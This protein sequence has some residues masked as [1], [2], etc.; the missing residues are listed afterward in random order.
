MRVALIHPSIPSKY[1]KHNFFIENLKLMPLGLLYL[2]AAL[3]QAGFETVLF[4]EMYYGGNAEG[5]AAEIARHQ[6]D[7]IGISNNTLTYENSKKLAGRLKG[8][9]G[10]EPL[11]VFGGHHTNYL[12]EDVLKDGICDCVI[13]GEAEHV[14]TEVVKAFQSEKKSKAFFSKLGDL[15]GV[16]VWDS[17]RQAV[18]GNYHFNLIENLDELP[19][20]DRRQIDTSFYNYHSVIFSRGCNGRCIFCSCSTDYRR[21]SIENILDELNELK[22]NR[23]VSGALSDDVYFLDN[24]FLADPVFTDKLLGRF[25][26]EGLRLEWGCEC[27]VDQIDPVLAKRMAGSGCKK[28]LFGIESIH[29]P[30]QR[31]IRKRLPQRDQIIDISKTCI[32]CGIEVHTS[33][34]IGLPGESRESLIEAFEFMKELRDIGAKPKARFLIPYPGTPVYRDPE[35]YNIKI[36]T[37]LW[38]NYGSYDCIVETEHLSKGEIEALYFEYCLELMEVI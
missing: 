30:I 2:S 28:V 18:G 22:S 33:F 35:K 37:R 12:Y 3:E 5:F 10:E 21:R 25:D 38:D 14:F 7:V 20:P 23:L 36:L 29:Q 4:D 8:I 24:N 32:D 16:M 34:V 26:A 17:E 9:M 1:L 15:T 19:F 31:V 13:V 6:P 11:V 27:R